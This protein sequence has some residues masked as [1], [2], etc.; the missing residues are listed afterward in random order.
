MRG[1]ASCWLLLACQKQDSRLKR[2]L[3]SQTPNVGQ[4]LASSWSL[5]KSESRKQRAPSPTAGPRSDILCCPS[6][7]WRR[8]T[9]PPSSPPYVRLEFHLRLEG[10]KLTGSRHAGGLV[11]CGCGSFCLFTPSILRPQGC[12]MNRDRGGFRQEDDKR[13]FPSSCF[14]TCPRPQ[15]SA[16]RPL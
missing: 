5:G 6:P 9:P 2:R 11:S 7:G 10:S 12:G 1:L 4:Q 14:A 16:S 8:R 15:P 13:K 3:H